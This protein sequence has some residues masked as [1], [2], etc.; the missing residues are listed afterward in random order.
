MGYMSTLLS[1]QCLCKS[2]TVL[3]VKAYCKIIMHGSKATPGTRWNN[4]FSLNRD[5]RLPDLVSSSTL[6]FEKV[7]LEF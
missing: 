1:A 3:N 2:K 4:S 7:P 6:P 5:K